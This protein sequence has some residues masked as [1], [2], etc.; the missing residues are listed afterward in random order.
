LEE[1]HI[2]EDMWHAKQRE[3]EEHVHEELKCTTHKEA[4]CDF[5]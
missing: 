1:E 3:I 2:Q 4:M 5:G